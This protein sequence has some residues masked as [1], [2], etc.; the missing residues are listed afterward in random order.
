MKVSLRQPGTG[1]RRPR[2]AG[3]PRSSRASPQ[4]SPAGQPSR[5]RTGSVPS[6]AAPA[7][8][9]DTGRGRSG[10]GN[11]LPPP[12]GSRPGPRPLRHRPGVAVPHSGGRGRDGAAG[13]AAAAVRWCGA[14]LRERPAEVGDKDAVPLLAAGG[15]LCA[16]SSASRHRSR[17]ARSAGCSDLCA[18]LREF[19]LLKRKS[20]PNFCRGFPNVVLKWQAKNNFF[21]GNC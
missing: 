12:L 19:I 11:A 17:S 16:F 4:Y 9:R 6:R 2:R 7:S 10:S 3:L 8:A 15:F 13:A 14:G 5:A 21:F 18:S 20:L 1:R